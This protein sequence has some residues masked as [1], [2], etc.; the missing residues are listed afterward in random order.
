MPTSAPVAPRS[1]AH[2]PK[3]PDLSGKTGGFGALLRVFWSRSSRELVVVL[4]LARSD[5]DHLEFD[6]PLDEKRFLELVEPE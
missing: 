5:R 3:S 2:T 1:L 6:D 4:R